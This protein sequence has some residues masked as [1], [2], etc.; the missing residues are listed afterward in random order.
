MPTTLSTL[1]S[2]RRGAGIRG[3]GAG[4]GVKGRGT[5]LRGRGTGER[6]SGKWGKRVQ[7]RE[8]LGAGVVPKFV[9]F[10]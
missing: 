8:F 7:G 6:G 5:G 3:Q 1:S 9:V 2:E 4:A 10:Y